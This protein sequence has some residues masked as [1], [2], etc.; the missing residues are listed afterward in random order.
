MRLFLTHFI[1]KS[2][3][4]SSKTDFLEYNAIG[5]DPSARW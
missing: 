1:K 3:E 2:K 5:G 4:P